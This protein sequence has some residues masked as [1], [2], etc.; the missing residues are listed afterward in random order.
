MMHYK[1]VVA[2]LLTAYNLRKKL[3]RGLKFGM[4]TAVMMLSNYVKFHE[5]K[6]K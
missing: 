3:P 1:I 6:E 5:D 2:P 4:C